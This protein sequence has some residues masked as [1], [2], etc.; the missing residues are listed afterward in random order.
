MA[1]ALG[2]INVLCRLLNHPSFFFVLVPSRHRDSVSFIR[3][4]DLNVAS[5]GGNCSNR[6]GDFDLDN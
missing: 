3:L 6:L 4:Y 2:P 5:N 1:S